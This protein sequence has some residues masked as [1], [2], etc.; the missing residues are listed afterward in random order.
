MQDA[1]NLFATFAVF[2]FVFGVGAVALAQ[3]PGFE[4]KVDNKVKEGDGKPTLELKAT[5]A[6]DEGTAKFERSDGETFTKKLDAMDRGDVQEI[7]IDQPAGEYSY[8]VKLTAM[9]GD[10]EVDMNLE[11]KAVVAEGLELEVDADRVRVDEGKAPVRTNRPLDRIEMVIKDTDGETLT[12]R[13]QEFGGKKGTI[14]VEWP[15]EEDV[16]SIELKAYDVDGFWS[17]L[18]LEPFWVEIPNEEVNF[19]NGKATWDDSEES[20]LEKTHERIR[21]EMRKHGDKGLEMKLYIAGYTDTVG[22]KSDNLELSRKRAR[23]L[24]RWFRKEGLDIPVYY[25]GFG[26]SVLAVDTPDE[27]EEPKNRRA[28]YVL[29]NAQPPES[30]TFPK[31]NWKKVE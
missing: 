11:F 27:T 5:G 16:G 9:S 10:Q 13:T 31:S 18:T 7:P 14:T 6:I 29:G 25:Q 30:E 2:A 26:E 17:S 4:Y 24:A 15:V 19:H 12:D 28:V 21:E 8:R 1:T 20:K 3:Q 23:A 22:S